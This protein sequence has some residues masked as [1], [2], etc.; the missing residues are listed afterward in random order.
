MSVQ[1]FAGKET[2][3]LDLLFIR[4][5]SLH[6]SKNIQTILMAVKWSPHTEC[7]FTFGRVTSTSER[8]KGCTFHIILNSSTFIIKS[9]FPVSNGSHSSSPV[10]S[11]PVY[12]L[13]YCCPSLSNKYF[14]QTHVTRAPP[15]F[16]AT[17]CALTYLVASYHL[18]KHLVASYHLHKHTIHQIKHF[19]HQQYVFVLRH[20]GTPFGSTK[21]SSASSPKRLH[22]KRASPN[23]VY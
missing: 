16:V 17:F 12:S 14:S 13:P 23:S 5:L 2:I 21:L 6:S 3:K 8:V 20:T 9:W 7:H 19:T 18:H 15:N 11:Y 22:K 1:Q 10:F 4:S